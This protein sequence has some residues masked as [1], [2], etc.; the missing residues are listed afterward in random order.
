MEAFKNGIKEQ[1]F[2][3]QRVSCNFNLRNPKS[4]KPTTIFMVVRLGKKQYK[5]PTGVKVIPTHWSKKLQCAYVGTRLNALENSNNLIANERIDLLNGRFSEFLQYL[6]RAESFGDIETLKD[7]LTMGRKKKETEMSV[8]DHFTNW[9]WDKNDSTR[10]NYLAKVKWLERFIDTRADKGTITFA[11]VATTKFFREFQAWLIANMKDREGKSVKP[12]SINKVVG[13]VLTLLKN[14]V[15]DEII[16]KGDYLNI[17]V[18]KLEDKSDVNV[19]FLYN[20]EIMSLYRY[21][22]EDATDAVVKDVFLLECTTGQRI[23]DIK[24]LAENVQ[25][26]ENGLLILDLLTKKESTRVRVRILFDIA[27]KILID[28]YNYQIPKVSENEINK[29]IKEIAHKAGLTRPWKKTR[30]KAD[31]KT[32]KP[33]EINKPLYEFIT[34]H[35]GRHSFDCLLKMR[36]YS[37]EEI[38]R[39]AGHD[40]DMVKRYTA[41]CADIDI[42]DYEL[43]K[44]NHPENIVKLISEVDAPPTPINVEQAPASVPSSAAN[45]SDMGKIYSF[46]NER[47]NAYV[48]FY[49]IVRSTIQYIRENRLSLRWLGGASERRYQSKLQKDFFDNYDEINRVLLEV[50]DS[51]NSGIAE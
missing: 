34:T 36:G 22:C 48:D 24:A 13:T 38:S 50:Q 14:A 12:D 19:P 6:C 25:Q 5:I 7:F 27:R 44:I 17:A 10:D 20:S 43:T 30:H 8:I 45:L 32:G 37:Y 2:V 47:I 16:L 51:I 49:I 9:C 41:N 28:K 46:I 11:I 1:V 35:V 29:R 33:E 3:S 18:K 15:N 40:V 42:D 21:E 26:G 4:K 31:D 23:S 39:Y